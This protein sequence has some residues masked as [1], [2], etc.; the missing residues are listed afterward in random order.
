M[1]KQV[2]AIGREDTSDIVIA[3]GTVSPEHMRIERLPDGT[4]LARSLDGCARVEVN[5]APVDH[6][7]LKPGDEIAIGESVFRFDGD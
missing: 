4:V 2:T 5:G 3:D 7:E 6:A 1:I